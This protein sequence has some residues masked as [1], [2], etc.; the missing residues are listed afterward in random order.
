MNCLCAPRASILASAQPGRDHHPDAEQTTSTIGWATTTSTPAGVLT[1][2]LA[3]VRS[4]VGSL[5]D[6]AVLAGVLHGRR[7]LADRS[8]VS[9]S[10]PPGFAIDCSGLRAYC[11]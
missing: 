11:V 8:R 6:P 4:A 9:T 7:A 10:Q 5:G 2:K 3:P 1:R